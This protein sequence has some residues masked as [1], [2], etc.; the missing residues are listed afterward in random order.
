[1]KAQVKYKYKI[2]QTEHFFENRENLLLCFQTD[3][4]GNLLLKSLQSSYRE[5]QK[6]PSQ[7]V[8]V[9]KKSTD[10]PQYHHSSPKDTGK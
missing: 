9:V 5:L 2:Y 8:W 7:E 1:M 4:T 3:W 6:H 10:F